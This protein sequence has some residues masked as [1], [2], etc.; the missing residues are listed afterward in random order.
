MRQLLIVTYHFPPSAASGGF[1]ILGFSRHLPTYDWGVS[2]VAPPTMPWEAVD[3]GLERR[4][5]PETQVF[6]EPYPSSKI[7]RKFVGLPAWLPRAARACRRAI[8]AHPVDAV[9]TSGPPHCVHLVGL[10]LKRRCGLP[11]AADFRD[12]W[13]VNGYDHAASR[14]LSGRLAASLE[15]KVM[16]G[17]EAII[18]NAPLAAAMLA[19]AYP[20]HAGKITAITNGYDAE[21]FAGPPG[22]A[23]PEMADDAVNLVHAG[24]IYLGRDPRPLLDVLAEINRKP[25]PRPIRLCLYGM[26]EDSS[27]DAD[28]RIRGLEKAIYIGGQLP[29]AQA[30]VAMRRASILLL[31]DTPGRRL[32]V[33]AKLYEYIGTGRPILALGELGGDL[34]WVLRESAV[35]YRIAPPTDR[36]EIERALVELVDLLREGRHI[37]PVQRQLRFAREEL[38]GELAVVLN[39]LC[40]S[41]LIGPRSPA[42]ARTWEHD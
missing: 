30:L 39:C 6:R 21:D 17:A 42:I 32:G 35:P 19:A 33:P 5:P 31:L 12:P 2:V 8:R 22:P 16:A 1:R 10:Y 40:V 29:H 18:T 15:R 27:L 3:L 9:L 41:A 38:A 7:A 25:S 14:G 26:R 23:P 24:S 37:E 34:E 4:I 11:W 13:I 28:S 20:A 36:D